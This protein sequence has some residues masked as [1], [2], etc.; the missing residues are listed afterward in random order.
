MTIISTEQTESAQGTDPSELLIKEAREAS[1]RR[2]LGW[3]TL[4][5]IVALVALLIVSLNV[6]SSKPTQQIG[7]GNKNPQGKFLSHLA[8]FCNCS[9]H[10]KRPVCGRCPG[11]RCSLAHDHEYGFKRMS[12][13][14]VS[15]TGRVWTDGQDH[16]IFTGASCDGRIRDDLEAAEAVCASSA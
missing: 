4:F 10:F 16:P 13:E 9:F 7:S 2:R 8:M 12:H 3:L 15:T 11:R 14:R 6:G 5:I 1:R